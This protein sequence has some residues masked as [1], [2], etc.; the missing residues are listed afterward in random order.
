M[1][2]HGEVYLLSGALL[3]RLDSLRVALNSKGM[4]WMRQLSS[5]YN[6]MRSFAVGGS[7]KKNPIS[8]LLWETRHRGC[9]DPRDKVF[10]LYWCIR[11]LRDQGHMAE[12]PAPN[13]ALSTQSVYLATTRWALESLGDTGMLCLAAFSSTSPADIALPSWVPDFRKLAKFPR[14]AK[15]SALLNLESQSASRRSPKSFIRIMPDGHTLQAS[16]VVIDKLEYISAELPAATDLYYMGHGAD[17]EDE[18]G[19]WGLN[20]HSLLFEFFSGGLWPLRKDPRAKERFCRSILLNSEPD[21][22][23]WKSVPTHR[24][25]VGLE[26]RAKVHWGLQGKHADLVQSRL[27]ADI[28]NESLPGS[29]GGSSGEEDEDCFENVMKIFGAL[30]NHRLFTTKSG[31]IGVAVGA[32]EAGDALVLFGGVDHPLILR[33]HGDKFHL[34]GIAFVHGLMRDEG[35]PEE[36]EDSLKLTTFH[37]H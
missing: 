15:T 14:R 13:Y 30:E 17:P 32:I 4:N 28:L 8:H 2:G 31:L 10:A 33:P 22:Q 9:T 18:L 36:P 24:W 1:V 3:F 29:S 6:Q 25:Y 26:L 34:R 19:Q 37:I 20:L 12:P 21:D 16:G 27:F 5:A 35:W 11:P 7:N 23:K